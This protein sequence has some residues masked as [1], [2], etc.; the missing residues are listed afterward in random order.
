MLT[1]VRL[2]SYAGV[3]GLVFGAAWGAG[4]LVGPTGPAA[5]PAVTAAPTPG[6]AGMSA[7]HAMTE[8]DR[9]VAPGTNGLS[10]TAANYTLRPAAT[11][12]PAGTTTR[13]DLV[14][15]APDGQP[16]TA[17]TGAPMQLLVVRRDGAGLQVLRPTMAPD[18]TW[19]TPLR[20]P[21][22]GAW[23]VIASFTAEG[24]DPAV[25]GADVFAPGPFTPLTFPPARAAEVDGYQVRLDGDLEAGMASA[26][27]A[28]ISK[29]GR[30]VTDLEPE[31]GA[32]GQLVALRAGDLAYTPITAQTRGAAPADRSG[33]AIAFTADLPTDGTYRVFLLFRHAGEIHT[34]DFTV[35]TT[36]A[37]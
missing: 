24:E 11:V 6:M 37:R 9:P 22:A 34:A 15:V 16:A 35:T 10:S 31:G 21:T 2:G 33:P 4:S 28:T 19:S 8:P 18:G 5:P 14:I 23:R 29:G 32:F 12:L 27:Y 26:L 30:A 20:L 3:L 36:A 7:D 25:L 1:A 13:L 17:F